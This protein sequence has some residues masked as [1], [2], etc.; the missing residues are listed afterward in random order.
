MAKTGTRLWSSVVPGNKP[1]EMV[2]VEMHEVPGDVEASVAVV[3]VTQLAE[4]GTAVLVDGKRVEVESIRARVEMPLAEFRRLAAVI[5]GWP[6]VA[7]G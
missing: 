2:R 7:R 6:G 1:G 4:P 3:E 5:V